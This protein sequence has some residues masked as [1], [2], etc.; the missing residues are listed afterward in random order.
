MATVKT[1]LHLHIP[2][3]GYVWVMPQEISLV[4][5]R[6]EHMSILTYL[7]GDTFIVRVF[8]SIG[9]PILGRWSNTYEVVATDTGDIG[10]LRAL[11][12]SIFEFEKA[13]HL[14]QAHFDQYTISTWVDDHAPYNPESFFVEP[15]DGAPGERVLIGDPLPMNVAWFLRRQVVTGRSGK[16]FYRMAIGEADVELDGVAW[17]FANNEDMGGIVIDALASSSLGYYLPGGMAALKLACIGISKG[18]T[19]PITRLVQDISSVAPV[20]YQVKHAWY[21]QA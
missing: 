20:P 1:V 13:L 15:L 18:S 10:D 6:R 4:P 19:T 8:K 17:V 21:N 3:C 16:M 14:P 12:H 2:T 5:G 7:T 9:T 11:G